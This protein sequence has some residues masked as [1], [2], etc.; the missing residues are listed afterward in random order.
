[1]EICVKMLELYR[2]ISRSRSSVSANNLGVRSFRFPHLAYPLYAVWFSAQLHDLTASHFLLSPI[3]RT[4][5]E[6][7]TV[8]RVE[9]TDVYHSWFDGEPRRVR[10]GWASADRRSQR[11]T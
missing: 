11:A 8:L 5:T 2:P 1:M 7:R 3:E 10:C 9:L 6:R 4:N